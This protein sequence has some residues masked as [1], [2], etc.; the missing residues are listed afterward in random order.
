ML[1]TGLEFAP[2]TTEECKKQIERLFTQGEIFSAYRAAREQIKTGDLVLLTSEE[3]PTKF[4]A[5]ERA[6]YIQHIK[7]TRGKV[8]ALFGGMASRSAHGVVQLPFEADAM[9]LVVAREHQ[10]PTM[11]V[12][13]ALPYEVAAAN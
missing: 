7:Q 1:K 9:W 10:V 3:N 5:W 8:P 13:F 4:E 2:R 6:K 12:I 11:T